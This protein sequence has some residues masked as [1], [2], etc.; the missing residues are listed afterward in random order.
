MK[1]VFAIFLVLFIF[2]ESCEKSPTN[3]T[4]CSFTIDH[5]IGTYKKTSETYQ[6]TPL[7][8]V[9]DIYNGWPSCKKNVIYYFSPVHDTF[10][11]NPLTIRN[12]L[13]L[14]DTFNCSN[15][16][17]NSYLYGIQNNA[18]QY[19]DYSGNELQKD[20]ILE[21]NCQYFK[22]GYYDFNGGV[23]LITWTRQ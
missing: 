19:N 17:Y 8:A 10:Y 18:I 3:N 12:R 13:I 21:F 20:S 9:Q 1:Q 14:L 5:L 15:I 16:G 22:T 7:S 2:F 6:P 23:T 11:T 4:N